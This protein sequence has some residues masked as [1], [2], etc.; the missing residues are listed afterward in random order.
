M[1]SAVVNT[2]NEE[3]YIGRCLEHL[4][5]VDEIVIIDMYS[6]D[7]SV[8]IARQYTD[9]IYFHPRTLSAQPARNFALQKASGDWILIVD[10]DEVI[11]ESLAQE[12][13]RRINLNPD[14]SAL[15]FP[16]KDIVWDRYLKH[17]Y[18][19]QWQTRLFRKGCVFFSEYVHARPEVKGKV[20]NLPQEESFRLIHYNFERISQ[21]LEKTNRYT[22]GEAEDLDK[23]G[24]KFSGLDLFKKPLAE[25]YCRYFLR[26]GYKDG[27]E[28]FLLC[29]LMALYRF[30]TWAKLWE[31]KKN[32]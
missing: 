4:K 31:M 19:L 22:T 30:L 26:K 3:K 25:F 5:W 32:R 12:I 10:P 13:L 14:F 15:A 7:K 9:K 28:G 20:V 1:I 21:F 18:P 23:K 29:A 16:R 8:E 24:I 27:M 17:V 11:P 6:T 2:C